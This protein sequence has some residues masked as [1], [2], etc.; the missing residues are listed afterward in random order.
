MGTGPHREHVRKCV[1]RRNAS[2][3]VGVVDDRREEIDREHGSRRLVDFPYCRIVARFEPE[4]ELVLV[5]QADCGGE[6][7]QRILEVTRTPLRRSTALAGELR[8]RNFLLVAHGNLLS[9]RIQYSSAIRGQRQRH[10]GR[11]A[12]SLLACHRAH[13]RTF[14]GHRF[15]RMGVIAAMDSCASIRKVDSK[16]KINTF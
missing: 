15:L 3:L 11:T 16:V 2:E 4:E 14:F 10:T 12:L 6:A 1:R 8:Q 13:D 7:V 5:R 9:S